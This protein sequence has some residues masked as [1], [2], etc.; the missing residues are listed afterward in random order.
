MRWFSHLLAVI[1]PVAVLLPQTALADPV[2]I[3]F[4]ASDASLTNPERGFWK[5]A[6]DD[7]LKV[8][9]GELVSIRSQGLSLA[10]AIVR[11]DDYRDTPLPQT[12]LDALQHSFDLTR[13]AGLK[14]ILRF[15]YNYPQTSS[16]Y[17]GAKDASLP[18]VLDHIAQLGPVIAANADVIAVMQAGFIGAW[19]EAHTSSNGL[20]SPAAKAAIR[21]ALAAAIPAP[22]QIQWRYPAD[23]LAWPPAA[24]IRFGLHNDCFLSSDTDVG[25]YSE[26]A[27]TR[28]RQRAQVATLTETTFFSGETC[29]A[30]PTE[31]K[32]DCADALAESATFHL[33]ALGLDYYRV[34][35]EAWMQQGCYPQ[36]TNQMGY[37]LRLVSANIDAAVIRVT[38]TND[39]WARALQPRPLRVGVPGSPGVALGPLTLDQIG[40]GQT[41]TLVAELPMPLPERLCLTAPDTSPHLAPDPRYA[42][43]PA[44][45]DASGMGWDE[46]LAAYCFS[47]P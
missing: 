2:R 21:D 18:V 42:I 5:F 4:P 47:L 33:S 45:G 34:F 25:T 39:G 38:L 26:D 14:V 17:E 35:H 28:T 6:A 40:A 22:L 27:D 16:E 11:L 13:Q 1:L 3:D 32:I 46:G 23:L 30:Q 7:F 37:R 29:D 43:R 41:V 44:N 12:V 24:R 9:P 36:I 19:G 20:D 31:I 8:D 15:S 10:Y